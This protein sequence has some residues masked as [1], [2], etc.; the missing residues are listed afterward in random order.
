MEETM[1]VSR[2]IQLDRL[3]LAHIKLASEKDESDYVKA[4][5]DIGLVTEV[6][7]I[8]IGY[9]KCGKCQH[10]LKFHL[11]NKNNGSLTCTTGTCK[12]CQRASASKSYKKTKKKRNY[13]KYYEEN[14]EVKQESARKYYEANKESLNAKHKEYLLTNKGKKVMQKAHAKRAEAMSKNQGISWKRE[15]VLDRD[16]GNGDFPICYLCGEA[17]TEI[18]GDA[19][20]ID[21]VVSINNGGLD[22]F[23]NVAATHKICNLTK[24]KDDRNLTSTQVSD[25]IKQSE[26]YMDE[27]PELFD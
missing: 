8:P 1:D 19:C 16:Q 20:H 13:K 15:W 6:K 12:E 14:K 7:E 17:I 10:V 25:L 23:T 27:H 21:H 11:F 2:E 24:E 18:T 26:I 22:C 4:K 5:D 9:K 3:A